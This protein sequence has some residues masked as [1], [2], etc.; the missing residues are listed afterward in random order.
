LED[1]EFRRGEID[2]QWLEPR[3]SK[4]V[5]KP[6]PPETKRNAIIVAALLAERDRN[7]LKRATPTHP[8]AQVTVQPGPSRQVQNDGLS[9]DGAERDAGG[10]KRTARI[11]GLR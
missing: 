9:D 8:I 5:S 2:I 6:A 11:E 4:L 10:W 7:R 1:A 3:L